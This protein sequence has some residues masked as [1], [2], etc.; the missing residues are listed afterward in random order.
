VWRAPKDAPKELKAKVI[1]DFG[2]FACEFKE[3]K[4][5]LR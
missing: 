4:V 2:P 1:F 5:T 3:E